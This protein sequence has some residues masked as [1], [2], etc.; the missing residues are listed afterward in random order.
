MGAEMTWSRSGNEAA[1]LYHPGCKPGPMGNGNGYTPSPDELIGKPP[2]KP[3][4]EPKPY[5]AG[6][7]WT[8]ED[9]QPTGDGAEL[10][11]TL[12]R[13][14]NGRV[15]ADTP[16]LDEERVKE[17][18]RDE[19]KGVVTPKVNVIEVRDAKDG[20]VLLPEGIQHREFETLL[21]LCDARENVW[22]VGPAGSGKT[23][24]AEHVAKALGLP[25]Y[26]TGAIDQPYGLL[27]FIDAGGK[28]HRTAFREAYE[29]GGV[30]LFDEIDG[31]APGAVLPFNAALAN[32]HCAFPDG[33]IAKHADFVCI[34]AANTWGLGGTNDYVG[35]L[36]QDAACLDRFCQLDWDYDE[37][38]EEAL[39]ANAEW[40]KRVQGLRAKAKAKGLK[41]IISPR[42]SI[43][44]AKLLRRGMAQAK[45]EQL[46]V[47]KAM[48]AE[49]WSSI[50]GY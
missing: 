28:L 49:Q 48:T 16:K 31:S 38:L 37:A 13:V 50:N 41:V 27:G 1:R 17:L 35:R 9:D 46:V 20:K 25:F 8:P 47:R 21:A 7:G 39:A 42:A 6:N 3:I 32:G 12:T 2:V 14:L 36:K 22:L 45:V 19:I 40:V 34:A 10:I 15:K 44:G 4:D 24:A 26:F 11:E 5:V 23:T 29:H 33:M 18:I 43:K 30:F